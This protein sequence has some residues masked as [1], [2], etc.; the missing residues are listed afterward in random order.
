MNSYS[1]TDI[2]TC[3]LISSLISTLATIV[4]KYLLDNR[5]AQKAYRRE[6][7]KQVFQRK[8]DAVERAMSWCQDFVEICSLYQT[9]ILEYDGSMNPVTVEKLQYSCS[10]IYKLLQEMSTRLNAIYLYYDFTDIYQKYQIAKSTKIG[11]EAFLLSGQIQQKISQC[12]KNN[13]ELILQQAWFK[14]LKKTLDIAVSAMN[15]QKFAII[16]IQQRL[17][18]DYQQYIK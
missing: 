8:T 1:L 18:T 13:E 15:N 2:I 6:L 11:S 16:E 3:G 14:Q 17:R 4:V 7:R 12:P 10:Q 5:S 9:S